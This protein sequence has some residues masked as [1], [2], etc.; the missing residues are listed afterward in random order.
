MWSMYTIEHYSAIKIRKF[1]V[2][3]SMN[4]PG[5]HNPSEIS[6]RKWKTLYDFIYM[7]HL[8]KVELI[9]TKS[10]MVVTREWG[11]R[12]CGNF[13]QSVQ[14]FSFKIDGFWR[15]NVYSTVTIVNNNVL[16]T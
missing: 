1:D 4:E 16:Y 6:W 15:P 14:T 3:Y 12:A 7:R 5:W 9:E 10:R 11:L 2:C 8:K 13:D